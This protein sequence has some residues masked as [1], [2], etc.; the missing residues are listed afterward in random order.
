MGDRRL[1]LLRELE[2][3]DAAVAAELTEL[4]ELDYQVDEL[5]AGALELEAFFA[6]L[7]DARADAADA[8]A[9]AER[10][11]SE[12]RTA[13]D[14][15]VG[16]VTRTEADGDPERL[17]EARRFEL[18]AR[19]TLLMAERRVAAVRDDRVELERRGEEAVRETAALE[20]RARELSSVLEARPRLT[21]EA[22][23]APEPGAAGVAEWGTRARAALLVARSQLVDERDAVVRQANELG[24][25]VL[26]EP[27]PPQGAAAVT[28][29][30]ERQ[31][32]G[33]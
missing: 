17:A 28:R 8:V 27:L 5:H 21:D 16:Q 23:A 20:A 4:D 11:L 7:P 12:A 31:L 3:A 30:V 19:D 2:R 14:E 6:D 29:R 13:A 9:T 26:G 18:R 10:R 22:V 32:G 24:A 25:V 33:R 1:E 15:A